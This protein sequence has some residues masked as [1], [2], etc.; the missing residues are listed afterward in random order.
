MRVGRALHVVD[1]L[2]Q[3][4]RPR[5]PAPRARS[6][7]RC[8]SK[9]RNATVTMRCSGGCGPARTWRAARSTGSRGE[10][11]RRHAPARP[12]SS[13]ASGRRRR[14]QR[15]AGPGRSRRR[16]SAPG[17]RRRRRADDDLAR[18]APPSP[19]A[20]PSRRRRARRPAA[21]GAS[22]RRGSRWNTP[23]CTPTRHAQRDA[24]REPCR[25]GRARAARCASPTARAAR[26]R[27][28]AVALEEQ[29]QRVA[30]ELQQAA[31]VGVGDVE[32][33]ARSSVPIASA[34][35]SA[36]SRPARASRSDSVVKPEMS[37]N[38]SDPSIVRTDRTAGVDRGIDRGRR[39]T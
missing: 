5:H 28:V 22:R 26:A 39:G 37:T 36:P 10:L 23:L 31:A 25:S 9:R 19:C 12:S 34:S 2:V 35:C 8:P 13:R 30:A 27:R 24:A 32:Q 38:T 6:A 17:A 18:A 11:A 15:A 1:E 20:R 29:Q 3:R 4:S 16:G 14:A 21:R 7:R 33:R